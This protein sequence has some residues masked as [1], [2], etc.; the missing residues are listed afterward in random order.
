MARSTQDELTRRERQIM[1]AIYRRGMATAADIQADLDDDSS[2]SAIRAA[3]WLLEEKGHLKHRQDGPR[4]VYY[5]SIRKDVAVRKAIASLVQTYFGGASDR[6]VA[7]ILEGADT[8]LS[9]DALDR[10][11]ALIADARRKQSD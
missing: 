1:E 5:P 10:I 7:A 11:E 2:Y 3:L 8:R 6:A 4:N 9:A